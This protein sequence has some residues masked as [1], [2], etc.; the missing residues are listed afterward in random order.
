MQI[1]F[2]RLMLV[3]ALLAALSA[4]NLVRDEEPT[5]TATNQGP[6]TELPRVV[7]NSPTDGD[8]LSLDQTILVNATIMDSAGV[9]RV[10]LQ[11]NDQLVK[12]I[13]PD[14]SQ[15]TD[16]NVVLD[17]A[18]VTTGDVRLTVIAARG[19]DE[20]EPT[21][22][23]VRIVS[24]TQITPGQLTNT[25][26]IDPEDPTCRALVN[27]NLNMR[28]GPS[29]AFD[30]IRIL[31]AGEIVPVIGRLGDNSWWQVQTGT[32]IGWINQPFT[33]TFGANCQ[34]V[35][36]VQPPPTPTSNAPTATFTVSPTFTHTPSLEPQATNT[37]GLPDLIITNLSGPSTITIPTGD[38]EIETKFDLTVTNTGFGETGQFTTAVRVLPS[39]DSI[40]LNVGGLRANESIVLSAEL[41]FTETGTFIVEAEADSENDVDEISEVN[42]KATQSITINTADD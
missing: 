11:A 27:V 32:R 3:F 31:A 23:T 36:V 2:L 37:P 19:A 13:F 5:P 42:N 26:A 24:D 38:S 1:R 20:S 9:N 8:E 7:I 35:P 33:S 39:G 29:T 17:Y 14:P 16:R 15:E 6:S 18:P 21:T 10:Q 25:P 34:F 22:V 30:V 4:C 40:E 12:T 28:R 41:T